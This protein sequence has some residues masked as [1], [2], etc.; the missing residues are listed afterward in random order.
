ML[1]VGGHVY[2]VHDKDTGR[3]K[4]GKSK[5]P[6]RRVKQIQWGFGGNNT[7]VYISNWVSNYDEV[8]VNIHNS[9]DSYRITGEFYDTTPQEI[10]DSTDSLFWCVGEIKKR[11]PVMCNVPKLEYYLNRFNSDEEDKPMEKVVLNKLNNQSTNEE[12]LKNISQVYQL[13]LDGYTDKDISKMVDRSVTLV[14]RLIVFAKR[15]EDPGMQH[16]YLEEPFIPNWFK[17][18]LNQ[19]E[20]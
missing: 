13:S 11:V 15:I 16:Q 17:E 3:S 1:E 8:E 19:L 4:V 18:Y 14:K 20:N 12:R 5:V 7:K 2:I 9:L 10:I 6:N